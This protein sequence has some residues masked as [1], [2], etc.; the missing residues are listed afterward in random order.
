MPA[1]FSGFLE[2]LPCLTFLI[3]TGPT[4]FN[5]AFP[6]NSFANRELSNTAPNR[7]LA[8]LAFAGWLYKNIGYPLSSTKAKIIAWTQAS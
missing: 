1:A 3:T 8:P 2:M 6:F 7:L 4:G 5:C